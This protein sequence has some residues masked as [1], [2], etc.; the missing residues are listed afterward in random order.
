LRHSSIVLQ[1]RMT[2][3]RGFRRGLSST[4][5]SV[6]HLAQQPA[7][8]IQAIRHDALN[9]LEPVVISL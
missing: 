7:V 6:L 8:A 4:D 5:R 1:E 3:L 9:R 2:L